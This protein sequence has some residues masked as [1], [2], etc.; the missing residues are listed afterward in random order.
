MKP[1]LDHHQAL[2]KAKIQ[3]MA[4]PDSA[5][6]TTVCFSL[7][8]MWNENIPT[9][10]TNGT[11]IEFSPKFFMSL[12]VGQ[13]I[14]LLLH[15]TMH[16]AYLHMARFQK[17]MDQSKANIAMDH[18]INL[19]LIE[20]GFE[21]PPFGYADRQYTGMCWEEVYKLLPDNHPPPMMDDLVPS[22][23]PVTDEQLEQAVQDILVRASIQS[24][25]S[26]DK[27]G[28]IPGD[29]QIFL[30][31]LL[32]PKLPWNKILSKYLHAFAKNDYSFRK[33]NRRF[34]P[35]YH[36]PSLVG[37]KL[38]NLAIAVDTSGSVS[39]EDFKVFVTEVHSI[40]RMMNPEQI[41]LI[42]FDT[43][44]KSVTKI[45]NTN[46]LMA[47]RFTGRGGT[48]ITPVLEWANENKPQL[49]L[50]FSDGEFRFYGTDTKVQTLWIIH[51]DPSFK[52]P[53]GRVIHYSI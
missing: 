31:K 53:F 28:T 8:H 49:L 43:A 44:I 21:M 7:K 9:A 5:F 39:D 23:D 52:A 48:A 46:E 20:R 26:N 18:V 35:R 1:V 50:V 11:W 25:M 38:I 19:Q 33:P 34:F 40:L 6:F 14:F 10:R 15:E 29:I 4:R 36:L 45:R 17:G 30:D 47:C 2:S 24:K 22:D 51:N 27:P 13:Q 41:Q 16:V 32:N 42:Q 37:E 3:L 12:T